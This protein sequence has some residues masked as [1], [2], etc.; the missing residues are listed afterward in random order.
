MTWSR[1]GRGKKARRPRRSAVT[2]LAMIAVVIACCL[3]PAC[4]ASDRSGQ[5]GGRQAGTA[6][7]QALS[8][9]VAS[10]STAAQKRGSATAGA[11]GLPPL[12]FQ[13]AQLLLVGFPGVA[14]SPETESLVRRGV[15]GLVLYGRNVASA[16]Q[17]RTLLEGVQA[18]AAVPLE[19]A[20]DEE[21]G[22]VARLAGL[23]GGAPTARELGKYPAARVYAQG[24]RIGRRLATLG[25]T[26]DLAPILDVTDAAGSSVIGDRSFGDDPEVV[27]RA[28]I[29]FER[30]LVAGGVGAV[31][32]HFPGHGATTTDSHLT[33]P[34]VDAPIERLAARDLKPFA[35]ATK[36]GLPA[37]MVGHLLIRRLDPRLPASLSPVIVGDLLRGQLGFGG[38]AVSDALEMGAIARSWSLPTAAEL[39]LRAGLD[40]LLIW[41]R[42][43]LVPQVI[44]RLERAVLTG[45]LPRARIEEAFRRVEQFK[46]QH[47]WDGCGGA[48][49]G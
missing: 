10:P 2:Q 48:S 39:A 11:C 7:A 47:R 9:I 5:A 16:G 49:G 20:V 43:D 29:A 32:K 18:R 21:P 34:V 3:L 14:V 37:V 6:V 15:G 45:R 28:G 44:D 13:I 24:L 31:G 23:I 27:S 35:L 4:G 38:L 30:G 26:T 33:L 46:G 25:V 22:R 17:L 19:I 40:Q 41:R 1:S 42:W 36:S 8:A 12:R